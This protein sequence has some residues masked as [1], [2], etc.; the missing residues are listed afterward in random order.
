MCVVPFGRD[1]FEVARH[2]EVA[3]AGASVKAKG[4]T[5]ARLRESIRVARGRR[6]GAGRIAQAFRA[7]GGAA[8]G[9][10][11]LESLLDTR[12]RRGSAGQSPDEVAADQREDSG[13]GDPHGQ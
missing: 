9:A 12:A 10:D 6:P 7:A 13:A 8:R 1:Q 3:R 4:L 11:E 2:V 5:A